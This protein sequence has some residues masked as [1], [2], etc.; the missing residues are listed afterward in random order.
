MQSLIN[1]AKQYT[2]LYRKP[3]VSVLGLVVFGIL[4]GLTAWHFRD[5]PGDLYKIG[6]DFHGCPDRG[7]LRFV[8]NALRSGDMS[9]VAESG[10]P[11]LSAGTEVHRLRGTPE[12]DVALHWRIQTQDGQ[13]LWIQRG[14]LR[15]PDGS[16]IR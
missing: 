6:A 12:A 10:C 14:W 4:A 2:G 9:A 7:S 5:A 1:E 13:A 8:E 15:N 16:L 11:R 3:H